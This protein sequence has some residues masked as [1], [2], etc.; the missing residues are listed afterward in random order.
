MDRRQNSVSSEAITG[1]KLRT[2]DYKLLNISTVMSMYFYIS[3]FTEITKYVYLLII[4][5]NSKS[6]K[7]QTFV[8][9][10]FEKMNF[11]MLSNFSVLK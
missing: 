9:K 3:P 5:W 1:I 7:I 10:D 2:S 6:K 11:W 8:I 4:K